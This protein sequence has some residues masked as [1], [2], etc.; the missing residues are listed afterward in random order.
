M[1]FYFFYIYVIILKKVIQFK[2]SA[3]I[4]YKLLG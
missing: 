1:L 3:C 4:V 2:V